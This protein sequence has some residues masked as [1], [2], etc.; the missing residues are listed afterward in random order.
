MELKQKKNLRGKIGKGGSFFCCFFKYL[1]CSSSVIISLLHSI[2]LPSSVPFVFFFLP[3]EKGWKATLYSLH[4]GC[5]SA[6]W[7]PVF[8]LSWNFEIDPS[9]SVFV[10]HRTSALFSWLHAITSLLCLTEKWE[11]NPS[12]LTFMRELGSGLFGVVRL[13]KWRAQY[14]V[15]IKAIRE[16]AMC[17][18]DFIE[19]AKVMM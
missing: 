14:N 10:S 6:L 8:V 18:E 15:A 1:Y 11:I 16:G 9:W 2:F 17:E 7:L 13:G 3:A 5:K 19:E 12:E 4:P